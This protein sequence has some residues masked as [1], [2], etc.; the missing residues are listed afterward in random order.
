MQDEN[1]RCADATPP[2]GTR[3]IPADDLD[4]LTGLYTRHG[5]RLVARAAGLR[6]LEMPGGT[7]LLL[8]RAWGRVP[9]AHAPQGVVAQKSCARPSVPTS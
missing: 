6:I 7:H 2:A 1:G 5:A 8:F 9:P 3:L 4:G